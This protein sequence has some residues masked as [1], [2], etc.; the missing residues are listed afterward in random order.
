MFG[1]DQ[2]A[3]LRPGTENVPAIVGLGVALAHRADDFKSVAA[4]TRDMRDAFEA[5]LAKR[6]LV[7]A[8]NGSGAPRLP[9]TSN[10]HFLAMDGEALVVQ[11]D[12]RGVRCPQSSA[13]TNQRPEPSYVL[14]AM[15]LSERQA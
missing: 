3:A 9:N 8:V 15:G 10:I 7:R 13:C 1:G 11:L 4:A 14:R 6:G 12:Q 5:G 2:E